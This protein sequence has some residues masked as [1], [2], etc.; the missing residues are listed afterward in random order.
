[1]RNFLFQ[2]LPLSAGTIGGLTTEFQVIMRANRSGFVFGDFELVEG[3]A[4]RKN[5]TGSVVIREL[6]AENP[7]DWLQ[8]SENGFK[9]GLTGF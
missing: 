6:M 2:C 7:S 3:E 1:M 8:F 9:T 5:L 4:Y